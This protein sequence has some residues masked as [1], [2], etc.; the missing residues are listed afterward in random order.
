MLNEADNFT[1]D[2]VVTE[3]LMEKLV[4]DAESFRDIAKEEKNK[5]QESALKISITL[6]TPQGLST[7]LL[8]L[9]SGAA[10]LEILKDHCKDNESQQL[11]LSGFQE[12]ILQIAR[13]LPQVAGR[14]TA[15]AIEYIGS[16]DRPIFPV[17]ISDSKAGAEWQCTFV[18]RMPCEYDLPSHVVSVPL[19]A[20]LVADAYRFITE[21]E[22][23]EKPGSDQ[24]LS[25]TIVTP[26]GQSTFRLEGFSCGSLLETIKKDCSGDESLLTSLSEFQTRVQDLVSGFAARPCSGKIYLMQ[27]T[28]EFGRQGWIA[29]FDPDL[30]TVKLK[31]LPD[32]V[33]LARVEE[34][35]NGNLTFMTTP[36]PFPE[37]YEYSLAVR[38][39]KR[40]FEGKLQRIVKETKA[41]IEFHVVGTMFNEP[42]SLNENEVWGRYFSWRH[43]KELG[44][45]MGVDLYFVQVDGNPTGLVT[46]YDLELRDASWIMS[47]VKFVSP[48]TITFTLFQGSKG[49]HEFSVTF[50][51]QRAYWVS[52]AEGSPVK[53]TEDVLRRQSIFMPH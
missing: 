29:C 16:Q 26:R 8:S 38:F 9:E 41:T 19:M 51:K 46:I 7:F 44:E 34:A 24:C 43:I 49:D 11:V 48:K 22:E 20:K 27:T 25:I 42:R 14:Y 12:R 52:L 28:S 39:T 2:D 21:E 5:K 18:L 37:R 33:E 13:L 36:S 1:A 31:G 10:L 45:I 30:K 4:A 40:G 47:N 6:V 17:V 53:G 50:S 32:W 15:L 35:M 3:S 23:H